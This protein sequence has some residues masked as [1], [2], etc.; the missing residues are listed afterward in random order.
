MHII[1]L[2]SGVIGVTSA[3]Y[4]A[5]AGHKVTV[6]DRQSGPALET[7][8]ANAG[9]ISPGYSAPWA[10][11]GVPLKA[12]KWLIQDL[13]PL[14]ITPQ[15]SVHQW[16]WM[17]SMLMNCRAKAYEVNKSRMLSVAEYSRNNLKTLREETGI[18][19]DNRSQGLIQLFRSDKQVRSSEIDKRILDS[20]G[21]TYETLGVDECISHEPALRHVSNKIRGGLRLPGDETGDCYMFTQALTRLCQDAGVE[22][23]FDTHVHSLVRKKGR[24]VAINSDK[25]Q[26]TADTYLV[27]MGSFSHQLVKPL[28]IYLP[29][30]PVK[31]YSITLPILDA[32]R[33]PEST[34]MDETHKVAVS[35]LGNRIRVGGT[36]E[37]SGYNIKLPPNRLRNVRHVVSDLFGGAANLDQAESWTGLRPMTPDGTPIIGRTPLENLFLNTGHG[38]LGWTMSVGSAKLVTD[39]IDGKTPEIDPEGLSISRY[40]NTK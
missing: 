25:G 17:L 34:V 16:R 38:T 28:G 22:F 3:W 23:R 4:L 5:Q 2:G 20:C 29:V 12:I 10:A 1:I 21:V 18:D 39:L 11:P 31:G 8:Y 30:Y 19:Y 9:Q 7:S 26:I 40:S 35:R 37:L 15:L 6:I 14:R 32:G 27:A 36:A 13:A 24:V 33:A